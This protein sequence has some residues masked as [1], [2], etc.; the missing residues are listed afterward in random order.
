MPQPWP[1]TSPPQA[2]ETPPRPRAG[3]GSEPATGSARWPPAVAAV[4]EADAVE[5]RAGPGGRPGRSTRAVKSVSAGAAGPTTRAR[6]RAKRSVRRVL[7]DHARGPVGLRPDDGAAAGRRRRKRDGERRGARRGRARRWARRAARTRRRRPRRGRPRN[8]RRP[9]RRAG[10]PSILASP[11]SAA[12]GRTTNRYP[13]PTTVSTWSR[14]GPELHPQAADV[15]VD[16]ARVH[17]GVVVAPDPLQ[18]PLAGEDAARPLDHA[19]E[20]LELLGGEAELGSRGSARSRRRTRPRSSRPG[21]P[22]AP[23]ASGS[24]RRSAARQ[25]A[26]SSFML[27]GFTT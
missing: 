12:R 5:D 11:S 19:A 16:A 21:S 25:R 3:C 1:A 8:C 2:N 23:P 13:I 17:V 4:L 26:A 15:R 6:R 10:H 22:R 20:Q 24:L 7:D 14:A 27:N 18:Q 9:S